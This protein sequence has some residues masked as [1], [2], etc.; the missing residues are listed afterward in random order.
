MDLAL[1]NLKSLISHKTQPTNQ[2][3]N[4]NLAIRVESPCDAM[5]K[6]LVLDSSRVYY[7]PGERHE[8]PLPTMD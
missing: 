5:A 2:I 6:V 8:P 1:N 3:K 7:Y 4:W